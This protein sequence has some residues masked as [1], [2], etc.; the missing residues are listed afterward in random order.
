MKS[1]RWLGVEIRCELIFWV[2]PFFNVMESGTKIRRTIKCIKLNEY[3]TKKNTNE[4]FLD[5]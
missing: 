3:D 4:S 5:D 1:K 2:L